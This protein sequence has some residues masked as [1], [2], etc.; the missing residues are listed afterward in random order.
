MKPTSQG[1][2]L[3]KIERADLDK[4]ERLGIPAT[5][6]VPVLSTI[7]KRGPQPMTQKTWK[8]LLDN[9]NKA[10]S[11]SKRFE[12]LGHDARGFAE[13]D[14]FLGVQRPVYSLGSSEADPELLKLAMKADPASPVGRALDSMGFLAKSMRE[15]SRAFGD[16]AR[17]N[18]HADRGV[19]FILHCIVGCKKKNSHCWK[20]LSR[21]L[22]AAF[23]AAGIDE[24]HIEHITPAWLCDQ[25]K[26]RVPAWTVKGE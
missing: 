18:K 4:L 20:P 1:V 3:D 26:R 12:K 21:L 10:K 8:N 9:R 25:A 15:A 16:I 11:L 14:P 2:D 24:K 6:L 22:R 19:D 13:A 5:T 17:H 23:R 7:V